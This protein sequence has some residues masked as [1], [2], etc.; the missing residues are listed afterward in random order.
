MNLQLSLFKTKFIIFIPKS[1]PLLRAPLSIWKSR[2]DHRLFPLPHISHTVSHSVPSM[3]VP[4]HNSPSLLLTLYLHFVC[5]RTWN[6]LLSQSYYHQDS[7]LTPY[8]ISSNSFP[9]LHSKMQIWLHRSPVENSSL[10]LKYFPNEIQTFKLIF[11]YLLLPNSPALSFITLP[12]PPHYPILWCWKIA[13]N[14]SNVVFSHTIWTNPLPFHI[15]HPLLLL[16]LLL[17]LWDLA[18]I[19]TFSKRTTCIPSV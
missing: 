14:F 4:K 13:F 9:R 16:K 17:S 6:H 15:S 12:L 1:Y 8:L 19:L 7:N 3:L 2:K 5:L 10:A 18:Q 11:N